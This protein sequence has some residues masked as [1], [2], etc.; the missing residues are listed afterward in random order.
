MMGI[1]LG[2][3][4]IFS[5]YPGRTHISYPGF[6]GRARLPKKKIIFHYPNR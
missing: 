2:D 3:Y 5:K 1:F 4:Y 6:L